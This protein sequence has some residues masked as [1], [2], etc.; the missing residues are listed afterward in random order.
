MKR[1]YNG[2][3]QIYGED[4][5]MKIIAE[6]DQTRSSTT[7]DRANKKYARTHGR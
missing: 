2:V 4:E 7:K 3:K 6:A 1:K 5:A